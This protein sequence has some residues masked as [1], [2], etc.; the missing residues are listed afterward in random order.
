MIWCITLTNPLQQ[1]LYTTPPAVTAD[2]Q[3]ILHK[4][5]RCLPSPN[6]LLIGGSCNRR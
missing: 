2:L 6:L 4:S 3:Q 5:S 1:E